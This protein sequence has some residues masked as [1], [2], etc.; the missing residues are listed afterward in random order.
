MDYKFHQDGTLPTEP[1]VFVFGSNLAGIHGAGAARVAYDKFGAVWGEGAQPKGQSYPIP[2]K[3][4]EIKTL[5]L[6]SIEPFVR[7]FLNHARDHND[8]QFF[9]TRIGCGLA[10]YKDSDIAPMFKGASDNCN[11][12]QEWKEYLI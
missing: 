3:D 12:P 2:T 10:G 5:P 9:I 6:S 1:S 7:I 8:Q 4:F 11:Y